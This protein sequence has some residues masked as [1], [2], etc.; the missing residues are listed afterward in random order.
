MKKVLPRLFVFLMINIWLT[1]CVNYNKIQKVN[2]RKFPKQELVVQTQEEL[3]SFDSTAGGDFQE[4]STEEDGVI[5]N[6]TSSGDTVLLKNNELIT[7][8]ENPEVLTQNSERGTNEQKR[9]IKNEVRKQ[10]VRSRSQSESHMS[11]AKLWLLIGLIALLIAAGLAFLIFLSIGTILWWELVVVIFAFAVPLVFFVLSIV[12]MIKSGKASS[13]KSE[14]GLDA[15]ARFK[16]AVRF[17]MWALISLAAAIGLVI[18]FASFSFLF[19]ALLVAAIFGA[20]PITFYVLALIQIIKSAKLS[21]IHKLTRPEGDT[22]GD[23]LRRTTWTLIFLG[24]LFSLILS[25]LV[26]LTAII[27]TNTVRKKDY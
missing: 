14:V 24:S 21:R 23:R 20:A 5:S 25:P 2:R 27:I 11:K 7:P 15:K 19:G 26:L 9:E 3:S 12:S 17:G 1:S 18:F 22:S 16:R 6:S 10:K 13:V 4:T 8:P